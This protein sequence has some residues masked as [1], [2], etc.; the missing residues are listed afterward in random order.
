M[1]TSEKITTLAEE[2]ASPE[3]FQ[4]QTDAVATSLSHRSQNYKSVKIFSSYPADFTEQTAP[5]W[6]SLAW[7]A[8][9]PGRKLDS[10]RN[11]KIN[12]LL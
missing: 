6:H 11:F 5:I 4:R 12:K 3:V 9:T 8:P 7:G 1:D 2:E 10:Q